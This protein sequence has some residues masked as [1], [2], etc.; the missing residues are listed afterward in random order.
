MSLLHL[1][2]IGDVDPRVLEELRAGLAR[3]FGLPCEIL[4]D[5]LDAVGLVVRRGEERPV[6][7]R[8]MTCP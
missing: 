2:R 5:A 3:G 8:A 1:M 6:D 7:T 4:P